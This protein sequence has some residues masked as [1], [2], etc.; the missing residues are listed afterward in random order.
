M[1]AFLAGGLAGVSDEVTGEPYEDGSGNRC[2][3]LLREPVLCFAA[4]REGLAAAHRRALSPG[5]RSPATPTRCSPPETTDNR[6]A[7]RAVES[8]KLSLAG[9]A[10]H[11]PRNSVDRAVKGL[12]LHR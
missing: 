11:G 10:L 8:E 7:V 5:W 4:D 6:A 2:L 9:L 12:K 3:P 1:T